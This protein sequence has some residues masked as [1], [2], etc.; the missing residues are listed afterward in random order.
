MKL[1]STRNHLRLQITEI[2][3]NIILRKPTQSN[4]YIILRI[5]YISN[6]FPCQSDSRMRTLY[7]VGNFN[8]HGYSKI[9]K[10]QITA[11]Y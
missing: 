5:D 1:V 8:G 3:Q 10:E 7:E 11:N 4:A 9:T 2:N 6:L